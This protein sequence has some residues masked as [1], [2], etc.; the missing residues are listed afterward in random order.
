MQPEGVEHMVVSDIDNTVNDLNV[1]IYRIIPS[2]RWVYP[3]PLP[4]GF[5]STPEGMKMLWDVPPVSDG[6][7]LL[8]CLQSGGVVYV[9]CKPRKVEELTRAWLR[10]HG[11]PAAPLVF[12]SG[13]EEKVEIAV[14]SGAIMALEMTQ[15]LLKRIS[16]LGCM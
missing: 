1:L 7:K 16:R 3:A 8:N 15:Q 4:E 14:V 2:A 9:T 10:R 13:P 11:F 12:C 5:W 6:A